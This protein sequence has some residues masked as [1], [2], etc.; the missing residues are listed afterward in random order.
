MRSEVTGSSRGRFCYPCGPGL[1][2]EE[3]W[4]LEGARCATL[5]ER[6]PAPTA[7]V[8]TIRRIPTSPNTPSPESSTLSN[9]SGQGKGREGKEVKG[10]GWI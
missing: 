4:I 2:A 8:P 9:M 10:Q 6:S 3:R 1:V 5:A 7:Q